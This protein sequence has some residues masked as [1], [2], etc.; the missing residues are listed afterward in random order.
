VRAAQDRLR[1][2]GLVG[3]PNHVDLSH[4]VTAAPAAVESAYAEAKRKARG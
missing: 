3:D 2:E 1:S 4:R